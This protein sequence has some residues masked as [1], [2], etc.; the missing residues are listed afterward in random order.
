M[1]SEELLNQVKE[2]FVSRIRVAAAGDGFLI[3]LP[4]NNYRG[5]PVEIGARP[6]GD[7]TI[8]IDDVGYV[9]GLLFE[10]NE[11]TEGAPGNLLT[12]QLVDSYKLKVDCD[13]GLVT[14]RLSLVAE[15]EKL[16]D[17]IKV[18]TAIETVLP[19][20]S[21][22]RKK[23]EG[24]RRL[25]AQV[26]REISQ[27]RLP[28]KVE[29]PAKVAGKHEIWDVEYRYTRKEDNAEI[30]VL[31]ADLGLREPRER[32]AHVI[33][34]ASDVL[35]AELRQSLRRELR[36]VY[37]SNG[38]HSEATRRAASIIDD[39]QRRIGYRAFNYSNPM[40]KALFAGITVQDLSPMKI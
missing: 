15:I 37:S 39:Y 11:H 7:G 17:F 22:P 33:T 2:E 16:L 4:F 12:K 40:A 29:R 6:Q 31:V 13:E 24:R 20:V 10:L 36:V 1:T 35:D 21:R 25:S 14:K 5:E 9:A 34:L 30:L 3:Q 23:V 18:I 38:D 26:S 32:A 8:L 28:L 19:F 27:L